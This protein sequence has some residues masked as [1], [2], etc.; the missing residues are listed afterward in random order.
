MFLVAICSIS[1]I[2]NFRNPKWE[3]GNGKWEVR[4]RNIKFKL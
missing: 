1:G 3:T 4:N 2:T